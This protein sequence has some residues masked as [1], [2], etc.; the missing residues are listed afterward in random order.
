MG[1]F[2]KAIEKARLEETFGP[3]IEVRPS[4]NYSSSHA[5]SHD[6][7]T[8]PK[9]YKKRQKIDIKYSRTKVQHHDIDKLKNNKII[10]FFEDFKPSNEIKMLHTQVLKRLKEMGGNSLLVTSA[11][12]SEGKTFTSINLGVSIAKEFDKTVLI[13]DADLRKPTREHVS[14]SEDFF[15]L[16]VEKGLSDYL[17]GEA[18][19]PDILINPGI[20]KLTLVPSGNPIDNS[21]ELLNSELMHEMMRDVKNR[22]P[23]DRL[24]IIDTPAML[25]FPDA[26][27]LSSYVDSVL[28]VVESENTDVDDLKKVG[29]LLKD[30]NILGTVFNKEKDGF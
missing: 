4:E 17:K 10:S 18:E 30:A 28:L 9:N 29:S 8:E 19:I 26:L 25:K 27:I 7:K 6:I 1:K 3:I 24:I 2:L 14:F 5:D 22:Y 21:P 15:S 13:I 23:Q 12:P 11:N 16:D 20:Q